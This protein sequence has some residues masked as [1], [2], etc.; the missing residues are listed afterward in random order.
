MSPDGIPQEFKSTKLGGGLC[1][2]SRDPSR[3]SDQ[4]V[5]LRCLT[6][7]A[8]VAISLAVATDLDT[9]LFH[10]AKVDKQQAHIKPAEFHFSPCAAARTATLADLI[11][12]LNVEV[13]KENGEL[14]RIRSLKRTLDFVRSTIEV[15]VS[16]REGNPPRIA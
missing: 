14:I 13:V 7:H 12:A 1:S 11:D 6:Y 4:R 15:D 5:E 9:R 16:G 8:N 3:A 10:M 2:L